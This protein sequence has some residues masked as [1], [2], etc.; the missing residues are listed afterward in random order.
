[1]RERAAARAR[2]PHERAMVVGKPDAVRRP[3]RRDAL[4]GRDRCERE[5]M[6]LGAE[7][8]QTHRTHLREQIEHLLDATRSRI[9]E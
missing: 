1:V 4:F 6:R 3:E 2:E 7:A 5:A 8:G 9:G